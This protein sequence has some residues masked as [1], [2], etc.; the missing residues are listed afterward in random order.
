M[1]AVANPQRGHLL[2]PQALM[3]AKPTG[4]GDAAPLFGKCLFRILVR[5]VVQEAPPNVAVS[6]VAFSSNRT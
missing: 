1:L 2:A 5:H 6:G 4:L 3:L